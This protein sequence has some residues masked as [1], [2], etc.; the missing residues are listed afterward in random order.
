MQSQEM[1]CGGR[2]L[3]S[4]DPMRVFA[5]GNLTNQ[6]SIEVKWRSG[7]RS[8]VNGV[9]ANRVYEIDEPGV[10]KGGTK[11]SSDKAES[12]PRKL[13]L[14]EGRDSLNEIFFTSNP[15]TGQSPA[16]RGQLCWI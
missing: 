15:S 3:S 14:N 8:V 6:M 9:R 5:A 11:P 12:L 7:R 10:E 2:Y 1:I 13:T 4:D 16:T